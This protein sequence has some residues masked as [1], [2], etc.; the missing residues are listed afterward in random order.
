MSTA[1]GRTIPTYWTGR[2]ENADGA[3]CSFGASG[4]A[5]VVASAT[6]TAQGATVATF[7]LIGVVAGF[8][9]FRPGARNTASYDGPAVRRERELQ[10]GFDL[11]SVDATCDFAHALPD[12]GGAQT[13]QLVSSATDIP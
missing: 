8:D 6:R 4:A 13:L 5:G 1:T 12:A 11:G 3:V 2:T 9:D 10:T 7:R